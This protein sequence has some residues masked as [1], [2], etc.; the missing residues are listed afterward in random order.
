[1]RNQEQAEA[2]VRILKDAESGSEK[3]QARAV[4]FV[5]GNILRFR[6]ER[7]DRIRDTD[8]ELLWGIDKGTCLDTFYGL[9]KDLG[10]KGEG[11]VPLADRG[12][13]WTLI[14]MQSMELYANEFIKENKLDYKPEQSVVEALYLAGKNAMQGNAPTQPE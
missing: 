9:A 3:D 7:F 14:T 5:A 4:G 10:V 12:F 6:T 1:M 11:D 2:A 13:V 8:A